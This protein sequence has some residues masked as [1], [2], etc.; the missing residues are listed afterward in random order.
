MHPKLDTDQKSAVVRSRLSSEICRRVSELF[1]LSS[2]SAA[3]P[4]SEEKWAV[5]Q[6]RLQDQ[7]SENDPSGE[8]LTAQVW[9]NIRQQLTAVLDSQGLDL[10]SPEV[11]LEEWE[12]IYKFFFSADIFDGRAV[13]VSGRA[14]PIIWLDAGDGSSSTTDVDIT[15][16]D[17]LREHEAT[18][19]MIGRCPIEEASSTSKHRSRSTEATCRAQRWGSPSPIN[20]MPTPVGRRPRTGDYWS[21]NRR[22]YFKDRLRGVGAMLTP[23]AHEKRHDLAQYNSA[24]AQV[25]TGFAEKILYSSAACRDVR[26]SLTARYKDPLTVKRWVE[27]FQCYSQLPDL[28]S[29][30]W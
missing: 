28:A 7:V 14:S 23:H 12:E 24:E 11:H 27:S 5:I 10:E 25:L 19:E 9:A 15:P 2:I 3:G 22:A 1:D 30:Q 6:Q 17:Y 18:Y 16:G 13:G 4:I 29:V 26:Q 21:E 8:P 20:S